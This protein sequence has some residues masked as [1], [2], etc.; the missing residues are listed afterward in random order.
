M[1]LAS[2]LSGFAAAMLAPALIRRRPAVGYLL[3]LLPAGLAI[4]FARLLS[5]APP[6]GQITFIDGELHPKEMDWLK[7]IARGNGLEFEWPCNE[8]RR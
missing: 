5:V 4:Y 7:A 6:R 8:I 2:V 1:I 3:A